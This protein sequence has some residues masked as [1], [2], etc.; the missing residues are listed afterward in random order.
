MTGVVGALLEGKPIPVAVV[1]DQQDLK[2]QKD[3]ENEMQI[4]TNE[5]K[6]RQRE[7]MAQLGVGEDD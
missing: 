6:K 7:L 5:P 3:A 4:T 1:A 2:Q